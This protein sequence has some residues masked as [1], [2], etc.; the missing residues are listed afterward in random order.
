MT[1]YGTPR[2]YN[3]DSGDIGG[4]RWWEQE[5]LEL[6]GERLEAAASEEERGGGDPGREEAE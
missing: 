4:K 6:A 2:G 5:D 1:D 3:A